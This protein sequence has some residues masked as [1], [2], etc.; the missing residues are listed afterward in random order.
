MASSTI[1]G[2]STPP[3]STPTAAA[4]V[5]TQQLS[6]EAVAKL[7]AVVAA[8][9]QGHPLSVEQVTQAQAVLA[10]LVKD[11]GDLSQAL[12]AGRADRAAASTG[13]APERQAGPLVFVGRLR[14]GWDAVEGLQVWA[15]ARQRLG[16]FTLFV[17]RGNSDPAV[18]G[19]TPELKLALEAGRIKMQNLPQN[20]EIPA[21]RLREA[22]VVVDSP[23]RAASKAV[24]REDGI[25]PRGPMYAFHVYQVGGS[26]MVVDAFHTSIPG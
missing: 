17:P 1:P 7:S 22:G 12:A 11:V 16:P 19:W 21:D 3:L 14:E 4:Q 8:A 20:G 18:V 9:T 10:S 2:Q 23:N 15:H 25:L 26:G 13:P 24:S 6:P 5:L